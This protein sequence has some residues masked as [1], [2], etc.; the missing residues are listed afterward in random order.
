MYKRQIV[1]YAGTKGLF[2]K[3][4]VAKL[5]QA[6]LE[7]IDHFHSAHSGVIGELREK[8]SLSD[9]L[10][11]SLTKITNEYLEAKGQYQE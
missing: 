2:D 5:G 8:K 7:L 11:A 9:D 6:Q 10:N 1:I 3:V 4:P